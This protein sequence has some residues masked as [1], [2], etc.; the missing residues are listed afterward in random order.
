VVPTTWAHLAEVMRQMM[1]KRGPEKVGLGNSARRVISRVVNPRLS[2]V[3]ASI[4]GNA[5]S[6]RHPAETLF[7]CVKRHLTTWPALVVHHAMDD[8]ASGMSSALVCRSGMARGRVR[9]W[10]ATAR[11]MRQGQTI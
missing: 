5:R 8:V 3:V 11:P 1:I 10:F 4:R 9:S 2:S 6:P 7:Y